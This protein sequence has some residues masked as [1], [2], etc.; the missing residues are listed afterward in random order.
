MLHKCW[1]LHLGP[2]LF[3]SWFHM[4][5]WFLYGIKPHTVAFVNLKQGSTFPSPE[6]VSDFVPPSNLQGTTLYCLWLCHPICWMGNCVSGAAP[7]CWAL[8]CHSAD[9]QVR[10]RVA[11]KA[12]C[13]ESNSSTGGWR[14]IITLLPREPPLN[15]CV[16]GMRPDGSYITDWREGV[17]LWRGSDKGSNEEGIFF[18]HCTLFIYISQLRFVRHTTVPSQ[19]SLICVVFNTALNS[20]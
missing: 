18:F 6:I 11:G 19:D 4:V 14:R 20:L 16:G 1:N 17:R 15:E 3:P 5:I 8:L 13:S 12:S 10:Q 7:V 9:W 2:L